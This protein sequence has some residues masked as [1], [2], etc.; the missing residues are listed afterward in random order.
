MTARELNSGNEP[1]V[2]VAIEKMNDIYTT[3]SAPPIFSTFLSPSI[4]L[5]GLSMDSSLPFPPINP[6][7]SATSLWLN[8]SIPL[9]SYATS[10]HGLSETGEIR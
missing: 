5:L 9:K 8:D 7:S 2:G 3:T 1:S 6:I 4:A 10:E